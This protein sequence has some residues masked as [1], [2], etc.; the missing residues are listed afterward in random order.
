MDGWEK[1]PESFHWQPIGLLPGKAFQR[2][3]QPAPLRSCLGDWGPP[4]QAILQSKMQSVYHSALLA[5]FVPI[6]RNNVKYAM[7][8]TF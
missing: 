3:A 7:F 8:I 6:P 1:A 5:S 4:Q 2:N